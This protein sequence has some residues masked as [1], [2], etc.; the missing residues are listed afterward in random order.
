MKKRIG[1]QN[2]K[3]VETLILKNIKKL[4]K[5]PKLPLTASLGVVILTLNACSSVTV[6]DRRVCADLG[7]AGARCNNTLTS[8]PQDIPK[9]I[10]DLPYVHENTRFGKLCFSSEDF[11]EG[12]T[13]LDQLCEVAKC[14]YEARKKVEQF[15]KNMRDLT[16]QIQYQ[17]EIQKTDKKGAQHE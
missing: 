6:R 9:E 4:L 17:I 15:K 13:A 16:T 1:F 7:A 11:T 8:S 3:N 5:K 10:W 2:L 14:D 12:E